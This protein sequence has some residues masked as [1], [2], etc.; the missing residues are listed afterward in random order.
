[1]DAP[2]QLP[3]NGAPLDHQS[4]AR[5]P[6]HFVVADQRPDRPRCEQGLRQRSAVGI[7]AQP[8]QWSIEEDGADCVA[9]VTQD[10]NP[11][12]A[13]AVTV[14]PGILLAN[15]LVADEPH[16]HVTSQSRQG[17]LAYDAAIP[18]NDQLSYNPGHAVQSQTL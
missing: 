6:N 17:V 2:A 5:G 7:P 1:L 11:H 3:A 13:A 14:P 16:L 9:R 4:I 18:G 12:P 8:R 15:Q 10:G